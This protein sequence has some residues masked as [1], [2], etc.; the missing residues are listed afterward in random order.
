M[1]PHRG[2]CRAGRP[3]SV[4]R[5][6]SPATPPPI[7]PSIH[8]ALAPGRSSTPLDAGGPTRGGRP[9]TLTM[10]V[11]HVTLSNPTPRPAAPRARPRA[12][13]SCRGAAH[14]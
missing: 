10:Q 5:P 4:R 8:R 12:R 3:R 2:A 11:H 7:H 9:F 14:V 1:A 13:V 6:T